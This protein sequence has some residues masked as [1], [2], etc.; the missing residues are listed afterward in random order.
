MPS[1]S[2]V[3]TACAV[4][5]VALALGS[6]QSPP[7]IHGR[8]T[9]RETI[10]LPAT[11]V[12]E[13]KV[14]DVSRPDQAPIVVARRIYSPLGTAPWPFTL[15]P[16]TMS[17]L[18]PDHGYAVQARILVDGKPVMVNKRRTYVNPARLADTLTI[19]VEPV[20]RTVGARIGAPART[21][22]GLWNPSVAPA[23]LPAPIPPPS[24]S[25]AAGSVPVPADELFSMTKRPECPPS[26]AH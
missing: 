26:P 16:D 15:R 3:S 14:V 17:T 22:P 6:C 7:E 8:V 13:V 21:A 5:C 9:P 24:A 1:R 18:D 2:R 23:T 25:L 19:V 11:A 12:L 10:A 20:P 4:A